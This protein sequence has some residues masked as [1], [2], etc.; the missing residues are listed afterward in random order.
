[1]ATFLTV[2]RSEFWYASEWNTFRYGLFSKAKFNGDFRCF[3]IRCLFDE[4][5]E[6]LFF[7]DSDFDFSTALYAAFVYENFFNKHFE[8]VFFS[9]AKFVGVFGSFF[10]KKFMTSISIQFFP[11]N[12]P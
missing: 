11:V 9:N 3:F 4:Y 7:L 5:L 10:R 2:F 8:T 12:E 6:L 1:M